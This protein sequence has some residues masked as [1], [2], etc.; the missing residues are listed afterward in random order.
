MRKNHAAKRLNQKCPFL[1]V[2]SD[3]IQF[4][5][6]MSNILIIKCGALGD[7]IRTSYILP[8][9]Y[10]KY[11][12]PKIYWLTSSSSFGLLRYNPYVQVIV[13]IDNMDILNDIE[14]DLVIS[15]D[16]E[17]GILKLVNNIKYREIVGAY[18][19]DGLP[20]YSE[21]SAMWFD[22][23]LISKLGKARADVLK[24]QN[25]K[26][27]NQIF[28]SMLDIEINEPIFFNSSL[29]ELRVSNYFSNKY[30]N[31][32]INS[33]A[34]SRWPSKQL[35]INE[36]I[37]LINRILSL[38]INNKKVCV[39]LLGGKEEASRH[40]II[41]NAIVSD[42]LIDTGNSNTLLEL[43]AIIKCCD[44]LIT[45][46]SLALHLAI[47]QEVN[48]LSFYAPTSAAEIGTFG[49]GVKLISLAEDYCSYKK[50]ADNYT[51]TAERIIDL[52]MKHLKLLQQR[53][54]IHISGNFKKQLK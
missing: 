49:C 32:G 9:I 33:G 45:S 54:M 18:L 31:I 37:S 20:S 36:S 43:A 28:A 22:M 25:T 52:M 48:N 14:F 6:T 11:N 35:I 24:K 41:K 40:S 16:D 7:V 8:G 38:E 10:A 19:S 51:L 27:H 53:K 13:T 26:K 4:A 12:C 50:Y 47:S 34:G 5:F 21:N 15:L 39:Y 29:I 30:F 44:Y 23:G 42:R 3:T 46:D 2:S 1:L 17:I